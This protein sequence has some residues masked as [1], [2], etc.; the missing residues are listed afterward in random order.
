MVVGQPHRLTGRAI[1]DDTAAYY[2]RHTSCWWSPA[3]E[4]VPTARPLPGTWSAAATTRR[5][6][7]SGR[8]GST[9][10]SASRH[11]CGFEPDLTQVDGLQLT[12]EA[13]RERRENLLLRAGRLPPAFGTFSGTLPGGPEP[14]AGFGVMEAHD[15]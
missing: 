1:I 12:A 13:A 10:S 4:Q 9:A 7:A 14:A 15:V 8:S 3:W 5:G 11:L 2:E 6:P